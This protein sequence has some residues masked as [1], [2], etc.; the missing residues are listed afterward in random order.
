MII[1]SESNK[2]SGKDQPL[3]R[4]FSVL[5]AVACAD[6]PMAIT[7]LLEVVDLP[8]STVHRLVAQL[9]ERDLVKRALGSK[10]VTVGPALVRL[11]GA[12]VRTAFRDDG[13]HQIL[14]TLSE[15]IGE[16]CQIG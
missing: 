5:N 16:H 7:E 12:A 2:P 15:Q 13:P 11:S 3:D 9:E 14:A 1:M 10:K 8:L 4:F 6:H